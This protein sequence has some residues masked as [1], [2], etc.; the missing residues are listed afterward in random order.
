M[1]GFRSG[2]AT[3]R[4]VIGVA[5]LAF[6]VIGSGPRPLASGTPT[7]ATVALATPDST[8]SA[9]SANPAAAAPVTATS[10]S[11]QP[12]PAPATI[13]LTSRTEPAGTGPTTAQLIGQ[14]LVVTMSGRKP[15]ASLLGRI[16]RGEIGGVCLLG[17]N[18]ATRSQLIALTGKLQAAATAGGQPPLLIA[19]DQEGGFVKRIP[20]AP[21]TKTVPEMGQID[22]TSVAHRQGAKTGAALAG[23]GL[24]VDFA[25]VADI[26]RSTASFMYQ[27][28]RTFSF[29]AWRTTAL[30]DAFASGLASK[31]VLATMKHFPGIG[32]ARRNTD[33]YAD[34]LRASKAVLAEDLRPYRRAIG[35]GVPL[36]M[37]SNATYTAYDP[38][39]AAGWSS[40][41]AMTLLRH[42]L[43]FTGVT[44]TDSL[45][46]TAN[47]RGV[48]VKSLALRAAIA[49]TDM[50]LTTG[51]ERSSGRLYATLLA[52]A[53]DD[54]IPL[55]T[56]RASYGR[57]LALK[58]RL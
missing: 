29:H 55:A 2:L 19:T 34:T 23:L 25:P 10:A 18:I 26:P 43:G 56:L 15:S 28:G 3:D 45:S 12:I 49:G 24:N 13:G 47:S 11:L 51:S 1:R 44:I 41:I 39:N 50:I 30:A 4:V 5:M 33:L 36:I 35:H 6:L 40:A 54:S 42:D 53:N 9:T 22:S 32:L 46:G 52:D 7:P 38:D 17:S 48:T 16:R 20:W 57:I 8:A 58:A 21:P 27:Q 14:K 31:G 37:L